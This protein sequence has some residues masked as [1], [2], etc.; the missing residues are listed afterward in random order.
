M[1][2]KRTIAAVLVCLLLAN[3]LGAAAMTTATAEMIE[4]TATTVEPA[5]L[6]ILG[7]VKAAIKKAIKAIDLRIQRL[8]NKTIWL[9]NAQKEIENTLSKLKLDEIS[10]W[11]EK[12]RDLFR[13]Y[14]DE[15][16]RVKAAITYYKRIREVTEKQVRLVE[17]YQRVW[18]ALQQDEHFNSEELEYMQQAYSGI[19][20]ESLEN[21]EQIVLIL[22]SFTLQ[23]S[24]AERLELINAAADSIDQNYDDLMR[25]NRQNVMLSLQR[26][27][28]SHDVDRLRLIYGMPQ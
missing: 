17:E 11:V 14:Y 24:D 25:F 16:M 21:M 10:G 8:Q 18:P 19:I 1:K 5:A 13:E 12:Q 23:M 27:K 4:T 26:A 2:L 22:E 28:T 15:L 9:Q 7:L 3:P 20:A 6:P